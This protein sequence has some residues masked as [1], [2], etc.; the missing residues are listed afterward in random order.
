MTSDAKNYFLARNEESLLLEVSTLLCQ[1]VA[2][3]QSA[4]CIDN[5]E[6][7]GYAVSEQLKNI[8]ITQIETALNRVA[9]KQYS[10]E[11]R[12]EHLAAELYHVTQEI[13]NQTV[14][15]GMVESSYQTTSQ[16]SNTGQYW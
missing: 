14:Q 10:E 2:F 15:G 3:P 16:T 5:Q 8:S 11:E 13:S 4:I 7:S 1:L 9:G 12:H 6:M